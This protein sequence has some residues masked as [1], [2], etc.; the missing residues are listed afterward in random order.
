MIDMRTQ[1]RDARRIVVKIGSSL[2]TRADLSLDVEYIGKICLQLRKLH[3]AGRQILLVTS[4]AV[5]SGLPKL[6]WTHLPG[7]LTEFNVAA[8]VGQ[9]GL[10]S[11]Y[12][13]A[14]GDNPRPAQILLTAEELSHRG[15]YLNA[16]ATLR[17][18]FELGVLPLVNENDAITIRE[19]R[20]SDNDR[21][22]ALLSNLLEADAQ[23]IC[24]DVEGLLAAEPDGGP[25]TLVAEGFAGD[26]CL[27]KHVRNGGKGRLGSGGM[28]AK[29]EAAAIAARGGAHTVIASGRTE[30][31]LL[32]LAAGEELGT[33]LRARGGRMQAR[34]RWLAD[35]G[36]GRG[37]LHLD[38]G[39]AEAVCAQGRSLLPVG[40]S[41]VAGSF[42]RGDVVDCVRE[43][44]T[45]VARGLTNYD[46]REAS[47]IAKT[48]SSLI[49]DRLG[50]VVEEEMIHR[51]NMVVLGGG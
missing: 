13:A 8:A 7:T 38:P 40:V 49:S 45:V 22:A 12:Q 19:R 37:T 18:L 46:S 26:R 2:L 1:I 11:A 44:G 5:A 25:D 3:G 31:F 6:G 32:R 36:A 9:L 14:L 30:N 28:K 21:L 4:G 10:F 42:A 17:R 15:T 33:F 50:Y 41:N 47:L 23:L 51:D 39:A 48:R 29:L 34:K 20:F 35:W 43:D 16:R 27:E 24:T